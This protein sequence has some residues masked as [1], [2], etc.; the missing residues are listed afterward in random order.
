MISSLTTSDRQQRLRM[1][2]TGSRLNNASDPSTP[3]TVVIV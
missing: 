1:V 3:D 2:Q